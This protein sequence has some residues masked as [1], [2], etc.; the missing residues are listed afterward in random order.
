M[1]KKA[2]PQA[3]REILHAVAD[4]HGVTPEDITQG[5]RSRNLMAARVE[6]AK[7]LEARGYSGSRIGAVLQ[8]NP[9]TVYFYLGRIQKKAPRL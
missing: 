7:A 5:D 6:V 1:M 2:I 9:T 4:S 3:A 8:R